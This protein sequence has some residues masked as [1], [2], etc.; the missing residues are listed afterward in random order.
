MLFL[1]NSPSLSPSGNS[2]SVLA[3][4]IKVNPPKRRDPIQDLSG[5]WSFPPLEY[6]K[7]FSPTSR[8]TDQNRS[9]FSGKWRCFRFRR[10]CAAWYTPGATQSTAEWEQALCPNVVTPFPRVHLPLKGGPFSCNLQESYS[11]LKHSFENERSVLYISSPHTHA[12]WFLFWVW[13]PHPP[14]HG[15]AWEG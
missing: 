8:S 3:E 1:L 9:T 6:K 14:T 4:L 10:P 11:S 13:F 7:L 12:L 2:V 15:G 5:L